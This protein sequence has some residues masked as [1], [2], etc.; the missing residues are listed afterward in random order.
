MGTITPPFGLCVYT[1]K[2]VAGAEVTVE[3]VFRAA[4]PMYFPVLVTLALLIAV[5]IIVTILP[6]TML[7]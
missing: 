4:L 5:P 1:V 6:N 2:A 3:G 7:G